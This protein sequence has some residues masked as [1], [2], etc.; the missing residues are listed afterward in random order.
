VEDDVGLDR[1][2]LSDV[3]DLQPR[4]LVQELAPAG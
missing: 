1:E 2:G 4:G 3:V